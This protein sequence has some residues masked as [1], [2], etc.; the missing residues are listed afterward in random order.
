MNEALEELAKEYGNVQFIK[1]SHAMQCVGCA[2]RLKE[3][4]SSTGPFL[5]L[6]VSWLPGRGRRVS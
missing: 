3:V 6:N 2:V 4:K 5:E 1:V